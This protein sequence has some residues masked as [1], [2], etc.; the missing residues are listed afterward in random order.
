[1]TLKLTLFSPET[2]DFAMEI[3]VDAD[4]TF[5]QFHEWLL[6][7]CDYQDLS[8][9]RFLI[10]DDE[11][12]VERQICQTDDGTTSVDE[13]LY[14]M[15]DCVLGDYLEEE[16]QTMAYVFDPAG[17]R[18]FL[19]E[20]SELIFGQPVDEPLLRR[21]HGKVPLQLLEA[22]DEAPETPAAGNPVLDESMYGDEDFA[23]DE[24][25]AEGFEIE[26]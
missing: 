11:L 14:L 25:D 24:L 5:Q 22:E 16:R 19:M 26:E 13:D 4:T 20:V 10:C 12:R 23:E 8:N 6:E 15:D 7:H 3:L 9:H 17:H 18:F 21:S 1:M 2:E